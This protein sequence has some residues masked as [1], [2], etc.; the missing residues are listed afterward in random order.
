MRNLRHTLVVITTC[1][2]ADWPFEQSPS[3]LADLSP[4][5]T[6]F[7]GATV[8]SFNTVTLGPPP[9]VSFNLRVPSKTLSGILKHKQFRVNVVRATR[10]GATI[11]H[12]FV[13]GKHEEAFEHAAALHHWVGLDNVQ[14]LAERTSLGDSAPFIHG[15]GIRAI[16]SCKAIPE[17]F[18]D[19]GDHVIV[20]AEVL[21]VRSVGRVDTSVLRIK[22]KKLAYGLG[23]TYYGQQ[24]R[25]AM[26]KP[27]NPV[28]IGGLDSD[29][30]GDSSQHSDITGVNVWM[31]QPL[32]VVQGKIV[33]FDQMPFHVNFDTR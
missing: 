11:A 1:K 25:D 24:Y 14:A 23:L 6:S 3:R 29:R 12:A 21:R 13:Q 20:V 16:I 8:S 4:F 19:V 32:R 7:C 26:S 2:D 28:P 5:Y 18:V 33:P 9:I 15:V 31:D 22:P 30:A 10:L 27:I 17:K